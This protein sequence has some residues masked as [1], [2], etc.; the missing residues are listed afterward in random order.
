MDKTPNSSYLSAP[1]SF[2]STTPPPAIWANPSG[3][4]SDS[5]FLECNPFP[6]ANSTLST[7][8]LHLWSI[9]VHRPAR[10]G[11]WEPTVVNDDQVSDYRAEV[12]VV[13]SPPPRTLGA[14]GVRLGIIRRVFVDPSDC[15]RATIGLRLSITYIYQSYS[16]MAY[17]FSKTGKYPRPNI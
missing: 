4:I 10:Y 7:S 3:S 9:Q 16:P 17:A 15:S 13:L 2:I 12:E 11:G 1:R 14:S 6:Q 5:P 8:D